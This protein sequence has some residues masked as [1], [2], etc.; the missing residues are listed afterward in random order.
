MKKL[1]S[2]VYLFFISFNL[3][4]QS[5]GSFFG[6]NQM[7]NGGSFASSHDNNT[8]GYT[9]VKGSPYLFDDFKN[10]G[11]LELISGEK[12]NINN[13]NINIYKAQF[14]SEQGKDSIFIF[15]NVKKA[16]IQF[17]EYSQIE[18][19]IYQL[20]V[21]GNNIS[22]LK[23]EYKVIKRQVQDKL[24]P[25]IVKWKLIEDYYLQVDGDLIQVK[26]RKKDFFNY[27]DKMK[28]SDLKKYIKANKLSVK[29]E[30]DLIKILH[31]YN[32]I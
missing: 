1:I 8:S 32:S 20:L 28:V 12:Y 16:T 17:K 4:G 7:L 27:L 24:S 25:E 30:I 6:S 14:V 18:N 22:F 19:N 3:L 9:N 21:V 26:L 13:I 2:I 31:Y 11:V 15:R 10:T 29:K 5:P 23:K